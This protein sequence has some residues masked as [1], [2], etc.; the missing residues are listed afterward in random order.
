[1]TQKVELLAGI[2]VGLAYST[3]GLKPA[4]YSARP[5]VVCHQESCVGEW[6]ALHAGGRA[7]YRRGQG[8]GDMFPLCPRLF[9]H[10]MPI[11]KC[12]RGLVISEPLTTR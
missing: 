2:L 9:P 1:M 3:T 12:P 6:Q 11:S 8:G 5:L 4:G 10:H 7:A